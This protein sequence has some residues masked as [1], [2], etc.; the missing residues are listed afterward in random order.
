V[1]IK[2]PF[3]LVVRGVDLET[4]ERIVASYHAGGL[5]VLPMDAELEVVHGMWYCNIH[6]EEFNH[7]EH[8]GCPSCIEEWESPDIRDL[9][10]AHPSE[11][12]TDESP[13]E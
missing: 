12:D 2:P 6:Q 5:I 8:G 10:T 11:Q 7:D 3:M 13:T 9:T 1:E 4:A